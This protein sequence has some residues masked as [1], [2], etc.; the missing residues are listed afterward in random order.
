MIVMTDEFGK[1]TIA[2]ETSTVGTVK[3][4]LEMRTVGDGDK[5][6]FYHIWDARHELKFL[7]EHLCYKNRGSQASG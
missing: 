6:I 1:M 5:S 3:E 4:E 2:I 7:L